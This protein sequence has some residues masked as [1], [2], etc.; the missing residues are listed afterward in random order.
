MSSRLL[1][2]IVLLA[3]GGS[4]AARD[5]IS[6]AGRWDVAMAAEPHYDDHVTLPG[7][8]LTN[9]KGMPLTLKTRWTATIYDSTF[10]KSPL[11][12]PYRQEGNIMLPFFLTPNCRYV[13]TAWYR[14]RVSVPRKW[15]GR[16][17]TLYLERPHIETT[18]FVNGQ[19][20][21]H[22]LSLSV[23]HRYDV[24]PY[25]R[26]GEK[27]EIAIR[28]YNGIENVGVGRDSHSVSDNAQGNWNG[29]TGR[30]ELQASPLVWRK[31]VVPHT[32]S[33]SVDVLINDTTFHIDLG[34]D[35][36][37]WDE[38][39]PRLYT[40]TVSYRGTPVAV[41]FGLREIAVQGRQL[42]INGRPLFL[43]GT[44]DNCCFP[45]TG[46]PPTDIEEWLR[47]F[48]KCREYGL[49]HVRFH[50]YCPPEAA[51]AAADQLGIYLQ[52]EGPSWPNHDVR[53][54]YGRNVDRY[55]V[56]ETRR[57]VDEY[58]HHPS[59]VL[60]TI[61]NE[62]NGGWVDYC[63]RWVRSM[64]DYDPT[65]LY[66][67]ASLGGGWLWDAS[68]QFHVKGSARGLWE[69]AR[70]APSS[71][72]DYA[73]GIS[74]PRNYK[75]SVPCQSPIITHEKGQWCAFPDL[76]ETPQY[77]GVY[78]ARNLELFADLLR[79]GGME[80]MA[81][82][83]LMA[84]GHLQALCYKYEI[85]RHLRTD[86]YAGFQLLGLSD[87]SGQGTSPVGV[88]NVFWREKG[89]CTAREWTQFCS[90]LVP[91]ARF[92]RFVFTTA[93]TL[94][95]PIDVYNA[96]AAPLHTPAASYAISCEERTLC[97]GDLRV[98]QAAVGRTPS[99]A[100]VALPLASVEAPAKLTLHVRLA[101][102]D[103]KWDFWV[104]PEPPAAPQ[105]E[106]NGIHVANVLDGKARD[107]LRKGGSVLLA[108]AG[109]VK[110][111]SN[112]KQAFLPVF[113]NLSWMSSQ[114]SHTT[115]AYI[116]NEHPLFRHGFPTD[117]WGNL[118]WWELLN[119]AQVMDIAELPA[120]YQP[121]VQPIHSWHFSR[122]LAMIIE[123]RVGQG[124]LLMTTIDI[125]SRLNERHVA[126]QMRAA[127]LSYMQSSD[128][129]P[130]I[131]LSEETVGHF[132]TQK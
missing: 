79:R 50:S 54:S 83:F 42:L 105:P 86:G 55:L 88:L 13:G 7:S 120:H 62:P 95:V 41:T 90:D 26:P 81:H 22:Q 29:I 128:F 27:N 56:E 30:M 84:S 129:N 112:V 70:H 12:E 77:T 6:L 122:K 3:L 46:Y 89:Y 21:G 34:P 104:Y 37:T 93:D 66:A 10:F 25:L 18:L 111:G 61:G 45:L 100:T 32:D 72:D 2:L 23:P 110:L 78:K 96:T 76:G 127:I 94:R 40:R 39:H 126:R 36:D 11:M 116:D 57:I 33:R 69:W 92:P 97:R 19:E 108:A 49:N 44:T 14:R 118:N 106:A 20:V 73:E 114:I 15:Q 17:L 64:T 8:M 121:P 74:F 16:Q 82:K 71:D 65:R 35:A 9:G 99:V 60:M 85:E 28:V 113:W 1:L 38:Y 98:A 48:G 47:I 4:A 58:G 91:L 117:S 75:D 67:A 124:R 101:G 103:N 5:V 52:V 125:D 119:S 68:S 63:D 115:G 102:H 87:Y 130:T 24:T 131:E 107:V 43:R 53:L 109:R 51:F 59:F 80:L 123:A 31:R 132:F